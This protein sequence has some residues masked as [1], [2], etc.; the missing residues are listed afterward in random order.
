M[1]LSA[2]FIIIDPRYHKVLAGHPTGRAY[3]YD[4]CYDIPKGHV[5]DGETPLEAAMRELREETG[6]VLPGNQEIY[7]IG[8]VGYNSKKSLHLFSTEMEVDLDRLHCDSMFTDSFG[9]EKREI[10]NF[11]LTDRCDQFFLNMRR[12]VI[13]EL[14][15]RYGLR[16]VQIVKDG[17]R[18]DN[19]IPEFRYE[20]ILDLITYAKDS[21]LVSPEGEF[22]FNAGDQDFTVTNDEVMSAVV[23]AKKIV[24]NFWTAL[25]EK[26][27]AYEPFPFN[28]WCERE[29]SGN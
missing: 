12:H 22:S 28:E 27:K 2:G 25:V 29:L 15:R 19:Y 5:E 6:L 18:I 11:M 14:Q 8:H 3:S 10:D 20:R 24:T 9:N 13:G 21:N 4:Y 17:S 23:N 26:G 16:L 1:E 7:E